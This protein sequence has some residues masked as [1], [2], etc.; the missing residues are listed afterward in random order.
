MVLVNL[1]P[2]TIRG[3]DSR[4]MLLAVVD[5]KGVVSLLA[6]DRKVAPGTPVL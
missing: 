2:K 1:E 3:V 6:A 5:E 4:G